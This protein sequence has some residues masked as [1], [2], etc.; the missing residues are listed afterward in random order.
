[1]GRGVYG[2]VKRVR[3]IHTDTLYAIKILSREPPRR[4]GVKTMPGETDDRVVRE[5]RAMA[6][7]HHPHV[8]RLYEVIDDPRSRRLF[9]V[10]EWMQG[11]EIP[12]KT[13]AGLPGLT[14][15]ETQR[16]LREVVQGLRHMHAQGVMHRD[17]KPANILWTADRVAKISDF[18]CAYVRRTPGSIHG[19]SSDTEPLL[20][21]TAGTPAFFAPELCRG[22]YEGP[23]VT[24]AIDVW[25]LGVTMYC[26]LF[27]RPPFW[28][29]TE[30]L[31]LETIMHADYAV[32]M[33]M[34]RDAVPINGRAP[35]WR[36]PRAEDASP[37]RSL[38]SIDSFDDV[39]GVG[40]TPP[41]VI[42][43]D[44]AQAVALLD[45][46]LDKDPRSRITLDEV[47][48]HPWL[49]RPTFS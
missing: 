37:V 18:G 40:P 13:H 32:P 49:T 43:P 22:P 42:A 48:V 29:E 15:A 36:W 5:I 11:G 31:L 46:L 10:T 33:H 35:R 1:M 27:G 45:R 2:S 26:L 44:A 24:Q 38:T 9:L 20:A 8:V 14:V 16:V 7:C 3:N 41:R 23:P 17:L 25:A 34:G 12:W 28:A 19:V 6:R 39:A 4:L 21:R 47:Q 30:Y